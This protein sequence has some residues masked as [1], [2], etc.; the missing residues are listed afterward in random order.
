MPK[1]N[2]RSRRERELRREEAKK[3]LARLNRAGLSF[4]EIAYRLSLSAWT[5]YRWQ[6]GSA[7]STTRLNQLRRLA[8]QRAA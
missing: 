2:A 5:L 3:I 1:M 8:A 7:P 4:E 6:K